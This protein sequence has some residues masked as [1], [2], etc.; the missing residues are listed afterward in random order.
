MMNKIY[1]LLLLP[2]FL[3]GCSNNKDKA[4]KIP[5][6]YKLFFE[7]NF[8]GDSLNENYWSYQIGD[9]TPNTGWGNQ[10]L[11]YYRKENVSVKDGQLH[12]TA[13]RESYGGYDFTSAR[14]RTTG[15]VFFKY[16]IVEARISLPAEKAMWPAFWMLPEEWKYGGWPDSGEI[17]I[18]EANGGSQY[19]T[20]CALH[21][22][23]SKGSDVYQTGY[24][25]MNKR[26]ETPSSITEFHVY[27]LDWQ[28][29]N[30]SFYV[31]DRLI[32][33]VPERTWSSGAVD[34]ETNPLAP[35]DQDFH[36]LLNMAVGGNYV[37]NV[38]PDPNF[39]SADMVVDYVRVYTYDE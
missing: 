26:G 17:D 21:Y 15:K 16:G 3:V 8:D 9:G 18:M 31:D 5:D 39:T 28:E 24:N 22:S 19:G 4:P 33:D 13:K 12:I 27:K 36:I 10:E 34:K 14:I 35:F 25:N 29:E 37:K 23:I 1:K 6:G 2:V 30:I 20:S 32:L 11:E 7:D 38:T